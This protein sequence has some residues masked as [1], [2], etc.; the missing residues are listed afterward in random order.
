MM[1]LV[2][3]VLI[4]LREGKDFR[5]G[6]FLGLALIKFQL[7][8]PLLFVLI[9]KKQF[10][11]L[12]GFSVVA[13]LLSVVSGRILGWEGMKA[14]PAYLWRLNHV[15]AAAAIFPSMMPSLR[16]LVQGWMNPMHSSPLL[17]L[18]TGVL[19]LAALIWASRQWKTEESRTSKVYMAGLSTV[20]VTVLLAGYHAF[21][22]DL[23]LLMPVVLWATLTGLQ[24]GELSA[25]ARR[26]LLLSS[27]AL[28]FPPLYFLLIGVGR[29]SWMALAVILLAWGLAQAI[30]AWE[31]KGGDSRRAIS[32]PLHPAAG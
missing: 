32:E 2:A 29:L 13:A 18:V 8:L 1:F 16:G 24:D 28:M 20:L 19:A 27:A 30:K 23:S 15:P 3:L 10:R 31:F 7:V 26:A 9:L 21:S 17:D 14:Y 12:T 25:A 4:H 11:A 22:Y 5:G 6:C